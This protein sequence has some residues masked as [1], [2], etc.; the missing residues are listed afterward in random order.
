M[1]LCTSKHARSSLSLLFSQHLCRLVSQRKLSF[2]QEQQLKQ[3]EGAAGVGGGGRIRLTPQDIRKTIESMNDPEGALRFLDW[4][5]KQLPNFSHHDSLTYSALI[6]TLAKSQKFGKIW[7]ILESMKRSGIKPQECDFHVL[8]K[9]YCE[10]GNHSRAVHAL[11]VMPN[12]GVFPS[13]ETYHTLLNY[14]VEKEEKKAFQL[15]GQHAYI[16]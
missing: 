10:D 7:E 4:A 14:L 12:Y 6:K 11:E 2:A 5:G 16:Y 3:E 15:N 13:S 9:H 8:I 1:A